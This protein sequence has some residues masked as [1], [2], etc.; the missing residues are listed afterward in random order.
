MEGRCCAEK[1]AQFLIQPI[2]DG[3]QTLVLL[4]ARLRRAQPVPFSQNR[5][6]RLAFA[7]GD[8]PTEKLRSKGHR[9]VPCPRG[10]YEEKADVAYQPRR[11]G[12]GALVCENVAYDIVIVKIAKRLDFE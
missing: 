6:R 8:D 4:K 11:K 9:S 3:R 10:W 12:R 7:G 5:F 2:N 1:A